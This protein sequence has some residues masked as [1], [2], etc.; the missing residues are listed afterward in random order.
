MFEKAKR[1]FQRENQFLSVGHKDAI[2]N[3]KFSKILSVK[4]NMETYNFFVLNQF[5][6]NQ[7]TFQ[8]KLQDSKRHFK[9][10]VTESLSYNEMSSGF[11]VNRHFFPLAVLNLSRACCCNEIKKDLNKS[12][13]F[14]FSEIFI[15]D[16]RRK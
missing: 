6:I 8:N 10:V 13:K 3:T 4:M 15:S 16:F 1:H 5:L 7:L 11:K 9:Q 12:L 14:I 2:K